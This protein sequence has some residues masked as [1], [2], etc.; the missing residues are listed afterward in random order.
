[1]CKTTNAKK[2]CVTRWRHKS[3]SKKHRSYYG[4]INKWEY[5][6]TINNKGVEIN[7][8][9]GSMP[10]ALMDLPV[11]QFAPVVL[12]MVPSP[13][14]PTT[15]LILPMASLFAEICSGYYDYHWCQ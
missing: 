12:Q 11:T 5:N 1:M 9:Y 2:S 14:L 15:L 10:F 4:G 7:K 6:E 3:F 13:L 8:L